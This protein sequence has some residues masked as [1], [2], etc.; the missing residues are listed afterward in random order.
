LV[1]LPYLPFQRKYDAVFL[2]AGFPLVFLVRKVLRW[3]RPVIVLFNT[4]YGNL[5]RRHAGGTIHRFLLA[6]LGGADAIACVSNAQ[7]DD[8]VRFGLDP[9][10]VEF[11]PLGVDCSSAPSER[12]DEGYLLSVG[13]DIARDYRTLFT[14]VENL[15]IP[16]RVICSPRNVADIDPPANVHLD[17]DL[18]YERL[19]EIY[20]KASLVAVPV[21]GADFFAGSDAS[22]Q[23]GFLEP[24]TYAKPVIVSERP[25]IRDYIS[26]N[27]DGI[28]VPPE[29]PAAL[30][31]AIL[32][33]WESPEERKRL[34]EAARRKAEK[35][36]STVR[37][38]ERLAG[39]FFRLTDGRYP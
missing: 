16:V 17:F 38:A 9:E 5:L 23:Y 29:D 32:G 22:G 11:I 4:S 21:R 20:R 30:R 1:H 13:R 39:L 31:K 15:P 6:A 28:L 14:A 12:S 10:R 18:P 7:K 27:E 34:G 35:E 26:H 19:P 37:F 33:L 3:K 25:G 36:F 2:G 8:L 24:M